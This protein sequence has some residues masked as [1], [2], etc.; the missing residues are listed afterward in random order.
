MRQLLL[1]NAGYFLQGGKREYATIIFKKRSYIEIVDKLIFA[2]KY[3]RIFITVFS[4]SFKPEINAF[5]HV[6]LKS[7]YIAAIGDYPTG[8]QIADTAIAFGCTRCFYYDNRDYRDNFCDNVF[9][10]SLLYFTHGRL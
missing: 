7:V 1:V 5:L 10:K 4:T 6:I 2:V 3:G 9:V 8:N